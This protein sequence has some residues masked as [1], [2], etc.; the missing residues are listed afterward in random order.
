MTDC[1]YENLP[2]PN[3]EP[4]SSTVVYTS[5]PNALCPYSV[6]P[7]FHSHPYEGE[8]HSSPSVALAPRT[9]LQQPRH[10]GDHR[11]YLPLTVGYPPG[12]GLAPAPRRVGRVP[13]LHGPLEPK[14]SD[15]SNQT[16]SSEEID[17]N[18]VSITLINN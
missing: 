14:Y 1:R 4:A 9:V 15:D 5:P 18:Y 10:Y 11:D 16:S 2:E 3:V 6:C 7:P 12:R 17:S 8:H 13:L